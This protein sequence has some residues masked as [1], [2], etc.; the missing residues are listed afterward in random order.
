M[1]LENL[2]LRQ[3]LAV[4]KRRCSRLQF[5]IPD[6]L[7]WGILRRLWRDRRRV[8]ILVQHETVIRFRPPF[9]TGG[10]LLKFYSTADANAITL[11]SMTEG[12]TRIRQ[13]RHYIH[14]LFFWVSRLAVESRKCN[15]FR[16]LLPAP[17]FRR[18]RRLPGPILESLELAIS[19]ATDLRMLCCAVAWLLVTSL[20]VLGQ[21]SK[22]RPK[23]ILGYCR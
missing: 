23:P 9:R 11:R 6:R 8:L 13:V 12:P 10:R 18:E 16:R 17:A 20:R 1:F 4:L 2:A 5:S 22:C 15:G 21:R 14:S 3:Q 7:F 19:V